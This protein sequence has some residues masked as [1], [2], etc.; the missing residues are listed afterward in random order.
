[1]VYAKECL[2]REA[3]DL[4]QRIDLFTLPVE[5]FGGGKQ[6][7]RKRLIET[8]RILSDSPKFTVDQEQQR[9][10]ADYVRQI[11][12]AMNAGDNDL[13]AELERR[14]ILRCEERNSQAKE[15]GAAPVNV[16]EGDVSLLTRAQAQ[17]F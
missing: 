6:E 7:I 17:G 15:G 9:D 2:D 14:W 4:A 8:A 1:M 11:T 12:E 13:V 5:S 16:W 3:A 10:E